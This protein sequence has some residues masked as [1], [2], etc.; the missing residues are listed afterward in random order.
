M[1]A[2]QKQA[3]VGYWENRLHKKHHITVKLTDEDANAFQ[4][5]QM[6][7]LA[8][9]MVLMGLITA[10]LIAVYVPLDL[11]T[12]DGIV[13]FILSFIPGVIAGAPI[14]IIIYTV[15]E[16]GYVRK[17]QE[18]LAKRA[19]VANVRAVQ[20]AHVR[21]IEENKRRTEDEIRQHA[22]EEARMKKLQQIIKV[23]NKLAVER[24]AQVLELSVDETW[25]RVFDWAEKF[26]FTIDGDYI[27]FNK[28]TVNDFIASMDKEFASWGSQGK[29]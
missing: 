24:I 6:K 5:R 14:G 27:L 3:P 21:A 22:A 7:F 12:I 20:E 11:T 2:Q 23:S 15:T 1:M 25:E 9:P 29:V 19:E 18:T 13:P 28:D 26:H 16:K 17:F 10:L 8:P 4:K